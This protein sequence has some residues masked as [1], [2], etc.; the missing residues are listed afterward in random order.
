MSHCLVLTVLLLNYLFRTFCRESYLLNVIQKLRDER[1][2]SMSVD[3][4]QK[5]QLR[6]IKE[7]CEFLSSEVTVCII[8]GW[9]ENNQFH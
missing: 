6:L 9:R 4:K 5:H 7:G 8:L 3:L 1:Q 2:R